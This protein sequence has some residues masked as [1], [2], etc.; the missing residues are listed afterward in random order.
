MMSRP[1]T[2]NVS[3]F[4]TGPSKR[5]HGRSRVDTASTT[6]TASST[7]TAVEGE[8]SIPSKKLRISPVLPALIDQSQDA[9]EEPSPAVGSEAG[10]PDSY[11]GGLFLPPPPFVTVLGDRMPA[12]P[13][14]TYDPPIITGHY[15]GEGDAT[16]TVVGVDGSEHVL[17][18]SLLF[19]R[20]SCL[21][22]L[23]DLSFPAPLSILSVSS[24]TSSSSTSSSPS[25]S[26][27]SIRICLQHPDDRRDA[28]ALCIA[29]ERRLPWSTLGALR[30]LPFQAFHDALY[31]MKRYWSTVANNKMRTYFMA[32]Q[33]DVPGNWDD[34]AKYLYQE[35]YCVQKEKAKEEALE[36]WRARKKL[37]AQ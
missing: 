26:F 8:V 32:K 34:P 31:Q 18:G 5:R 23:C 25:T 17:E 21:R 3:P 35:V 37:K 15:S 9:S 12:L 33:Y 27:S 19:Q 14:T 16:I 11:R 28:I 30:D 22:D 7:D 13:T 4:P 6:L 24:S 2:S 1:D 20:E 36:Q 29:A 10:S